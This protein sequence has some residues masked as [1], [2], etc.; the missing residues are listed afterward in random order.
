MIPVLHLRTG[1]ALY[2]A[3]RML[4]ALASATPAPYSPIIGAI[5]RAG[6]SSALAL[7]ADRRGIA[8]LQFPRSA[9]FDLTCAR[10]VAAAARSHPA[11]LLHA[12]GPKSLGAAACAPAL[13][14]IPFVA[15]V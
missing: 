6:R 3:E 11:A 14:R 8:A 4:L 15:T 10:P 7:E 1:E 13:S 5:S 9:R 12:H 2:G